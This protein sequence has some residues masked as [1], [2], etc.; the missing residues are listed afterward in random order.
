MAIEIARPIP[1]WK[2]AMPDIGHESLESLCNECAAL[3]IHFWAP[4]N[5][6]DPLMDRG[7]QQIA[8]Q[9]ANR[10]T[11][12]SANVDTERGAELAQRFGVCNV[13]TLVVLRFGSK[14]RLVI[15]CVGAEALADKLESFLLDPQPHRWWAFWR[16]DT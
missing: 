2:P 10:V 1:G 13:P 16:R 7:I 9:F 12:F 14:P 5:G 8:N 3:A 6:V 15:G 11:F 4:W